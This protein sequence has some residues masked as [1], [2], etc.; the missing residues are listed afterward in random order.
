MKTLIFF[1]ATAVLL[2]ACNSNSTTGPQS[3]YDTNKALYERSLELT[4]YGTALVALNFMLLE[5]STSMQYTDS[6]ARLYMRS[7]NFDAGLSLGKKV[8]DQN[9]KNYS[10]MELMATAYEYKGDPPNLTK[11]YR[12]YKKLYEEV[13]GAKYL[14]K[15]AQ[16]GMLQGSFEAA[17]KKLEEVVE[18]PELAYIE[19]PTSDGGIQMI[20][21]KAG[22]YMLLANYY[23]SEGD[24]NLGV[25]NLELALKVE[26]EYEA[27]R[28]MVQRLQQ[29]QQQ[30]A[31]LGQQ[32]AQQQAYQQQL[33]AE[34][35]R[36]KKIAA[37]K[38]KEAE[39]LKKNK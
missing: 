31:S 8:M 4:D 18:S 36:A 27:A 39:F 5:D 14:L 30:Q 13:G 2:T 29:Y 6:L 17:K 20:N 15:M 12:H 35:A 26:P 24:Q 37:E 34:Q 21:V 16:V 10:L 25:K 33:R 7:G 28:L 23:F 38:Q 22:A 9:E 11:S 19:S 3:S 1:L 32:Q